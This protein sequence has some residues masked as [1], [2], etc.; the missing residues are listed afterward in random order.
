MPPSR[1]D[2]A[3]G[4]MVIH[5][6]DGVEYFAD[7]LSNGLSERAASP[8]TGVLEAMTAANASLQGH[9]G[10]IEGT[11]VA[12]HDP[13]DERPSE[14]RDRHKGGRKHIRARDR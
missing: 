7:H 5:G 10:V 2:S 12:R 14:R 3:V 4:I 8:M 9:A 1:I 6:A 11:E 13:D